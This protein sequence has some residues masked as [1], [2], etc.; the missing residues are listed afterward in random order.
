MCLDLVN[1]HTSNAAACHFH[2]M[3]H[4]LPVKAFQMEVIRAAL[5]SG[6]AVKTKMVEK[7]Q[8]GQSGVVKP[9]VP[10]PLRCLKIDNNLFMWV[11]SVDT[12]FEIKTKAVFKFL[13][14]VK[15]SLPYLLPIKCI[16]FV[17]KAISLN[18]I[19]NKRV[20]MSYIFANVLGT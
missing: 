5:E 17:E 14:H 3:I 8:C 1:P 16:F 2:E 12:T 18:K 15:R 7:N 9:L 19:L 6:A 11:V 13:I 20:I 4:L 10:E